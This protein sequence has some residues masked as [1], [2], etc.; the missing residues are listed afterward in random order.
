MSE[1]VLDGITIKASP[2]DCDENGFISLW[3]IAAASCDGDTER[4]RALA[5]QFL[6]FLCKKSCDF[7]M[8]SATDATY[9][10]E[11]FE[12]DNKLLYDWKFESETVDVLSQHAEVPREPFLAVLSN[13]NFNPATK[14]SPKRADRVQWFTEM[15][16]VG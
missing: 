14:Y 8:V 7:V 1:S 4:T 3:R 6:G 9:L 5:A 10:D 15:W 12:R 16:S 2:E 13:Q 11:W